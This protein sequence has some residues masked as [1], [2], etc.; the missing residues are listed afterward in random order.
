MFTTTSLRGVFK[1]KKLGPTGLLIKLNMVWDDSAFFTSFRGVSKLKLAS[2]QF[3]VR[4][5]IFFFISFTRWPV[6]EVHNSVVVL[7]FV[8]VRDVLGGEK[9]SLA[10]DLSLKSSFSLCFGVYCV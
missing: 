3:S 5:V 4:L 6:G 10:K 1:V 7:V 8:V 9:H 2:G